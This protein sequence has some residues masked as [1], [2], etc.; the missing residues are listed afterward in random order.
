MALYW[1]VR[2][3]GVTCYDEKVL[4]SSEIT[5]DGG[6]L[7]TAGMNGI[8][9]MAF[10]LDEQDPGG[11]NYQYPDELYQS[12]GI[13]VSSEDGERISQNLF[14]GQNLRPF[15]FTDRVKLEKEIRLEQGQRYLVEA[16]V[17]G[18]RTEALTVVLYGNGHST[19][20]MYLA[21]CAAVLLLLAMVFAFLAGRSEKHFILRFILLG[22]Y[23][24]FLSEC[25]MV[26]LCVPDE[27]TH[28]MDVYSISN[29]IT[30]RLG[31]ESRISGS[32]EPLDVTGEGDSLNIT[33]SGLTRLRTNMDLQDTWNFWTD[34]SYGNVT[35]R[36]SDCRFQYRPWQL[37][38]TRISYVIPAAALT[39]ARFAHAPWQVILLAGRMANALLFILAAA[40][41]MRICPSFRYP[42]AAVALLPSVSFLASSFSYDVWNLAFVLLFFSVCM[43]CR[44]SAEG[45]RFRD[46]AAMVVCLALFLPVKFIY[47]T[48]LGSVLLIPRRQWKDKR[49]VRGSA[50]VILAA[51]AFLAVTRG[52]EVLSYL[53]TG[54]MDTRGQAEGA[55][56][57]TVS[58]ALQAPRHTAGL[59]FNTLCSGF[60]RNLVKCLDG[61]F[62]SNY[63]PDLLTAALLL[64]FTLLMALQE[65]P[66]EVGRRERAVST[67]ILLSGWFVT[68][69]AMLFLFNNVSDDRDAVIE[70][71]QGRYFLPYLLFLP[72]LLNSGRLSGLRDRILS[73]VGSAGTDGGTAGDVPDDPA[74][75]LQRFLLCGVAVAS[76]MILLAKFILLYEGRS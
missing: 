67:V 36:V 53:T 38:N 21:V 66:Q 68:L 48:L 72:M 73:R 15:A 46:L 18:E 29:R 28:F 70:G 41:S 9:E 17:G 6:Y 37:H 61:E 2:L 7:Y 30:D 76:T 24:S 64:P 19:L 63:L 43:R 59:F 25:V 75:R 52:Q 20:P 3:S 39:A 54:M 58:Y 47:F 27:P 10:C 50:A 35:G 34:W 23:F 13:T 12:V 11:E 74:G 49:V 22:L 26:P 55:Q 56:S 45:V 1:I 8:S 14:I 40:L 51:A 4:E 69:A 32:P 71:L 5:A 42:A 31:L 57:Y 33:E 65:K 60:D 44:E 16:T 62:F